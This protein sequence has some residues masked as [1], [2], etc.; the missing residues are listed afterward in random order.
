M[1]SIC[2]AI[3]KGGGVQG[4]GAGVGVAAAGAAEHQD[5]TDQGSLVL[6]GA[7][8]LVDWVYL[9]GR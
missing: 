7:Q 6:E 9:Q 3:S 2:I 8:G 1:R 5:D 4:V